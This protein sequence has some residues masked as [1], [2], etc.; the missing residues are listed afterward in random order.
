MLWK[1]DSLF[2]WLQ[3]AL[4]AISL[5]QQRPMRQ[6]KMFPFQMGVCMKRDYSKEHSENYSRIYSEKFSRNYSIGDLPGEVY[7][8]PEPI[9]RLSSDF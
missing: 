2:V 4:N 9:S 1:L 3:M 8:P 6:Q 5:L 7:R